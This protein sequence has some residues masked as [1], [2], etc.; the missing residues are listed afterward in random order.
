[1]IQNYSFIYQNTIT[2]LFQVVM[3]ALTGFLGNDSA[4]NVEVVY[5]PSPLKSQGIILISLIEIRC[6][7]VFIP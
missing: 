6:P 2:N 1:M 3:N 7:N 4:L 5:Q